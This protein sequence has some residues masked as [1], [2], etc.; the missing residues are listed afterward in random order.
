MQELNN[1][2]ALIGIPS[3]STNLNNL[4]DDTLRCE[5][6]QLQLQ[7]SEEEIRELSRIIKKYYAANTA[8][9]LKIMVALELGVIGGETRSPL[10]AGGTSFV[11]FF[12]GALPSTVPFALV[13][14]SN[15]GL[16]SAGIAT[17]VGLCIVGAVKSWATRGNFFLSALENLSITACGGG[18][19]YGIGVV[20]QNLIGDGSL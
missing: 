16:L 18:I 8:A 12:I 1:L 7:P 10:V 6:D 20:F 19:A 5:G 13:S 4:P 11:C 9:L 14:D 15:M 17:G 3:S 2:L